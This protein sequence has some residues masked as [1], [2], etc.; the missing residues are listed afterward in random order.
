MSRQILKC[1]RCGSYT[2]NGICKCGEKTI[3]HKPP[4]Y[5]P[6]DKYAYYRR[7]AKE[8]EFSDKGLI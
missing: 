1:V 2:M 4:K 6:E 8:K 7:K 3:S 5:S